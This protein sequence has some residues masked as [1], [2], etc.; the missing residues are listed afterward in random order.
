MPERKAIREIYEIF[1]LNRETR[2][3]LFTENPKLDQVTK[4][5]VSSES[6]AALLWC[7]SHCFS[8]LLILIVSPSWLSS[9]V[10]TAGTK[11]TSGGDGLDSGYINILHAI[12]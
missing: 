7:G 8:P 2:T 9:N 1:Y 5:A 4:P 12:R 10:N 3:F 11:T 6:A